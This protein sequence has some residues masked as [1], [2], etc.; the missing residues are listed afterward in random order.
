MAVGHTRHCSGA[1]LHAQQ[2]AA[3]EA[4]CADWSAF[5]YRRVTQE[6]R[7]RSW[8]VTHNR[9]SR[10]MREKALAVRQVE[11]FVGTT[12][13]DHHE[14]ISPNLRPAGRNQLS[15]TDITYSRLRT[16]FVVL[17]IFLDSRSRKVVGYA[18]SKLLD[19]H[20]PLAALEAAIRSRTAAPGL[21]HHS[22]RGCSMP[23][24]NTAN[25]V[26]RRDH[27]INV[28]PRQTLRQRTNQELH[29]DAEARGGIGVQF[30]NDAG[31]HRPISVFH[32]SRLHSTLGHLPNNWS[33]TKQTPMCRIGQNGT[34][35][36]HP[37]GFT[38]KSVPL[39]SRIDTM[40]D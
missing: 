8:R 6:L 2:R 37:E 1:N 13:G 38:P 4:I 26:L 23:R 10:L 15:V 20:L 25:A 3:V 35:T 11:R 29:E 33:E 34:A 19:T 40:T 31:C 22:D 7:R 14:P 17:A 32:R 36:V 16:E 12:D 30:R 21:I 5:G 24:D 27:G 9:I 18:V 28:T 39:M